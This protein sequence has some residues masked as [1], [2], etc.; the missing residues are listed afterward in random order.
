MPH[1]RSKKIGQ[2]RSGMEGSSRRRRSSNGR[3]RGKGGGSRHAVKAQG[4]VTGSNSRRSGER[5]NDGARSKLI[6]ARR[7][8]RASTQSSL[9]VTLS[10]HAQGDWCSLV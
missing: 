4:G 1:S 2:T 5:S 7:S 6:E 8:A 10:P 9:K 3:R